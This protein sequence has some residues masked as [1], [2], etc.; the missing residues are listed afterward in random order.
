MCFRP[1]CG[2]LSFQRVVPSL[3]FQW[4]EPT[5]LLHGRKRGCLWLLVL[6]AC[7]RMQNER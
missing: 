1:E 4:E 5:D 2:P 3:E 6:L 7:G